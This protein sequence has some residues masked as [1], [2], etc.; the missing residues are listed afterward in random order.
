MQ[1]PMRK[2]VDIVCRTSCSVYNASPSGKAFRTAC[3][4]GAARVTGD[5][6]FRVNK[7]QDEAAHPEGIARSSTIPNR[8]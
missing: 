7:E 6:R 8:K 3:C 5:G 1:S 2:G 4:G